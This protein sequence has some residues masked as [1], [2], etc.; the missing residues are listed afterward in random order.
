MFDRGL[1]TPDE[2]READIGWRMSWQ[3]DWTIPTLA[4]QPFPEKPP[5]AYWAS[6][7]ASAAFPH[8][9]AALRVPNFVFACLTTI[10]IVLLA[11]AAGGAAAAWIA[12]LTAGTFLLAV[13]VTSWLATDAALMVGV[14]GALLGAWRGACAVL[15]R[16]RLLW[17]ALMHASLA[18][19]FF[20]KGPSA[21]LVPVCGLLSVMALERK[22]SV[23]RSREF[24]LPALIPAAAILWWIGA[25][26]RTQDG[27][28]SLSVLLWSNVAGRF[29]RLDSADGGAYSQ[30]HVNYP[31]KYFA[32]LP[33][34]VAPW[35]FLF[36]A[37]L[38]R[39]WY[40]APERSGAA[41]RFATGTWL[42]PI[43]A[44]S[45]AST[46]RGIYFA[47][48]L[49][50]CALLI[51]LWYAERSFGI[52]RFDRA[53]LA[54]TLALM[55]LFVSALFLMTGVVAAA[56]PMLPSSAFLI[57][58]ALVAFPALALAGMHLKGWRTRSFM[59]CL[60]VAF[61][62]AFVSNAV[63]LLPA[64][65]RWQDLSAVMRAADRDAAGRT[66]VLYQP[67]ETTVALVDRIAPRRSPA[68]NALTL[69]ES[70][71]LMREHGDIAM[72]IL[73]RGRA[74]GRLSRQLRSWGLHMPTAVASLSEIDDLCEHLRLCAERI[75][76]VPQGRR[77]AL[78]A[79][80]PP[81]VTGTASTRV[82]RAQ[83]LP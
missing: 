45:F 35:I 81:A 80:R 24:W 54:A 26:V 37:A 6:G 4:G 46:G 53:M 75:Y 3:S 47:P 10:A 29:L 60:F 28:H 50:A 77:Y 41:W 55:A 25:T 23:L 82:M 74:D 52:D 57:I 56:E 66:L 62:V 43:I 71:R 22:W 70:A 14:T 83:E 32:E 30:G 48:A 33:F 13:Q 20:A 61:L 19:A 73:L 63:V 58:G 11:H 72:L 34:Y 9:V 39:A 49:P 21:L 1:W 38:R 5:L 42:V 27:A 12:G 17:F 16:E 79:R 36:A 69:D 44:L 15:R 76:E 67:D 8:R 51:G 78:L 40:R 65:D 64:I 7:A 2:P 31:G 59:T 18:W 68:P